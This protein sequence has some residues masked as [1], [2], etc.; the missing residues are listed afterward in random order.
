MEEGG[1]EVPRKALHLETSQMIS[2][3]L[4]TEKKKKKNCGGGVCGVETMP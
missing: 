4:S 3:L 1:S 2:M